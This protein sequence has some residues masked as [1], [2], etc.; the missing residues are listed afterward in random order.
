M[1]GHKARSKKGEESLAKLL[2][3]GRDTGG[4]AIKKKETERSM[5][6][7]KGKI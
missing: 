6:R 7:E 4:F 2:K 3:E 1:K 5:G